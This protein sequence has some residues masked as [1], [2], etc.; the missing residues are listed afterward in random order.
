M[1][2]DRL[3]K[4]EKI[5]L[6]KKTHAEVLKELGDLKNIVSLKYITLKIHEK[7]PEEPIYDI[8][9]I[10]QIISGQYK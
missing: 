6:V 5:A 2:N 3:S 1:A 9:T 7:L 8:R 4:D 10:G